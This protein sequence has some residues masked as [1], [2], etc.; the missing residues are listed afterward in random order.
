MLKEREE[1]RREERG[2]GG[3]EGEE[4]EEEEREQDGW[5]HCL[6]FISPL[7]PPCLLGP[8]QGET[9]MREISSGER[10]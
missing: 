8:P 9:E 10:K 2:E 7:R 6:S 1:G 5:E 3:R 4:K